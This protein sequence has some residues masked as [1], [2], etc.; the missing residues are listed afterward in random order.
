MLPETD[1]SPPGKR[2]FPDTATSDHHR[3]PGHRSRRRSLH[4]ARLG[5]DQGR[6][7]ELRIRGDDPGFRCP[8]LVRP[9]APL[10]ALVGG[11]VQPG[12]LRRAGRRSGHQKGVGEVGGTE[13]VTP[14]RRQRD[15]RREQHNQV[16][17]SPI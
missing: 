9:A 8:P 6:N 12:R 2:D 11:G 5:W 16:F 4:Q 14:Q 13:E 1:S 17:E 15:V 10:A 7:V 3:L